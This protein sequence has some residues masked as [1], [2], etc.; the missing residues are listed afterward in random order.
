MAI[1][2]KLKWLQLLLALSLLLSAITPALAAPAPASHLPEGKAGPSMAEATV[3]ASAPIPIDPGPWH[4]DDPSSTADN[5]GN[6]YATWTD[7]RDTKT[8]IRF[9]SMH[10]GDSSWQPSTR[11][12]ASGTA[13]QGSSHIASDSNGNLYAVWLDY[14]SGEGQV[15]FSYRPAGGTWATSMP[16]S[17]T[18][19]SQG[20]PSLAV[21]RRGDAVVAW[22]QRESGSYH[23][24]VF[25]ALRSAGGTWGAA[26]QLTTTGGDY[27]NTSVAIDNWGRAYAAW[28]QRNPSH[29]AFAMRPAGG[30][31]GPVEFVC[32]CSGYNPSIAV[33][34]AGN[35][36]AV[37]SSS[38][39]VAAYRPAGGPWSA[40]VQLDADGTFPGVG[41]DDAGNAIAVWYTYNY[42]DSTALYR[43]IK[44]A[45]SN[46]SERELL[47]SAP[48]TN[49]AASL[50]PQSIASEPLNSVSVGPSS[51]VFFG[52]GDF[53]PGGV[54]VL[55]APA[56][57]EDGHCDKMTTA[58]AGA[59][60]NTGLAQTG[61]GNCRNG[62]P[63]PPQNVDGGFIGPPGPPPGTQIGGWPIRTVEIEPGHTVYIVDTPGVDG[64]YDN[65]A[66][67][68]AF[69]GSYVYMPPINGLGSLPNPADF[70]PAEAP[71]Q[72]AAPL[73]PA[74]TPPQVPAP[75]TPPQV[76]APP[77]PPQVIPSTQAEEVQTLADRINAL[78]KDSY[79][80]EGAETLV[81][82]VNALVEA[83]V[84]DPFAQHS[85]Y[86]LPSITPDM[87]LEMT[88]E[89]RAALEQGVAL[90]ESALSL[91]ERIGAIS[92]RAFYSLIPAIAPDTILEMT[93]EQ[94]AKLE[95]FVTQAESSQSL[96]FPGLEHFLRPFAA[97]AE[98]KQKRL[99]D[100]I[101]PASGDFVHSETPLHI[102]GRGLDYE[103][104]VSYHAQLVYD[105]PVGWGWTHNDDRRVV[106]AGAGSLALR[107]GGGRFDV[108]S[109][110]GTNFT[111]PA[112]VYTTIVSDTAGIIITDRYGQV[113]TYYPLDDATAPGALRSI[114][115]RNGN[116]LTF[117]YDAQGRLQTVT[118]TLGRDITY[119][120]DANNR[121]TSVTDF[122]GRSVTLTY[123]S[124]GDL[125]SITT[126]AVTGTPNGNDF[127]TGKTTRFA[128][129]SG[130]TD[131]RLNHN[132]T[133][134]IAPN[135]VAD[136]SL[137][138]R[139][140]N[141]Y[142]TEG[143]A[144]DRV[145]S[146]SWGGGR[147]NASGIP[148][149][150]TVTLVY[151]STVAANDPT[152]TASKT[153]ITDR[154]GNVITLWYDGAGHRLRSRQTVGGQTLTTDYAYNA[155][156]LLTGTTYPAGNQVAYT[157]DESA[158]NR[159]ARGNMLTM[160][161]IADVT[162]GCDGLGSTPC[163]DRVT[164]FTYEATFQ[165]IKTITDSLGHTAT[166]DYDTHGNLTKVTFPPVTVGPAAPQTAFESWTYNAH[167]QPLTFTDAEGNVTAYAYYSSGLANGYRQSVTLDSGGENLTTTY[168]VDAVGRTTAVTDP[169]GVRTDFIYNALDQVVKTTR[170]ATRNTQYAIRYWY[171]ANDNLVRT[172]TENV[173]P[174][175]D[176]NAHPTGTCSRDT[177]N[178]WF[179]TTF[180]YDLLDNVIT[181]S[182]EISTTAQAVTT[183]RYDALE[184][185]VRS[186]GPNGNRTE[187]AYDE[188]NRLTAETQAAGTSDAITTTFAYDGNGNLVQQLDGEGHPTGYYYDGFDNPVGQVDALGNIVRQAYDANGNRTGV[189]ML[190]GQDGRNPGRTFGATTPVLLSQ[191]E[192]RFDERNRRYMSRGRFFTADVGSGTITPITTDGNGDG[193]VETAFRWD[194]NGNLAAL[195]DD[196]GNTTTFAYDGLNRL[197]QHTDALGNTTAYTYDGNSNLT[198]TVS[199]DHQPDA[200]TADQVFIT[201]RIYD[202]LNRLAETSDSLGETSRLAYDSRS[203]TVFRSDANGPVAGGSNDHGNTTLYAYDGL[204]RRTTTT[205]HL[206]A[207]GTGGGAVT[208][209]A[210]SRYAYDAGGNLVRYT[211]PDGNV[212]RYSYDGLDRLTGTTFADGT[213][214]SN[215]YNRANNLVQHTDANGS[216]LT[217]SYDALNRRV[218]TDVARAAGVVGSTRQTFAYDGL[219]RLTQATDN[220]DPADSGDDSA[221]VFSY[222]SLNHVRSETQDGKTVASTYDGV[223]NR[224]TQT[225]PGG[226]TLTTTYDA[227][228]RVKTISDGS[229]QLASYDYIGPWRVFRRSNAN[230][231]YVAYSYDGVS[232]LTGVDHRLS[233]DDSL[234]TGFTCALDRAGHVLTETAQPGGVLTTY[235]YDS[236]YRLTGYQRPGLT[237]AFSYDAAGNRTEETRNGQVIAYTVDVMNRYTT[238]GGLPQSYDANGNLA[239]DTANIYRYDAFN[240]LAGSSVL[241]WKLYLPVI[242]RSG[243]GLSQTQTTAF[244][245]AGSQAT[246]S[247]QTYDALNRR[248]RLTT[249]STTVRFLHDHGRAIE[250]RDGSDALVASY[251]GDL[252]M[253]R[254]GVRSFYQRDAGGSTRALA[255]TGGAVVERVDY[256]AFGRPVFSGGGDA[257]ALGNPI[258]WHGL[259]YD[260]GDGLYVLG[261]RRYDPARG[262]GLQP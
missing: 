101:L 180:A 128:Y 174:D 158:T 160:R 85:F 46:W 214:E 144:F 255:N 191:T 126:P 47:A 84:Q 2:T 72:A 127:P 87:I 188:Q 39:A 40:V 140:V 154:G 28:N 218:Q 171:D 231:T 190:D 228:N 176:A 117:A 153:I 102:A 32:D 252:F 10:H 76:P 230:G 239:A 120:Y 166:R 80:A 189:Q 257:S 15:H 200:L 206:R 1:R 129:T 169:R 165:Q 234:L 56:P 247:Q 138:A 136:G 93:P 25:A 203:N 212:T 215:V 41:V 243:G 184:R 196:R 97:Q 145:I 119:S 156:G 52:G 217:Y 258:L 226:M 16:I 233:S 159:L 24:Q 198:Q 244:G 55:E 201:T 135:E 54:S 107:T 170:A 108:Y 23:R 193:W 105:G 253:V 69:A 211:D 254:G 195:T 51:Y 182:V 142:G 118:D 232:R 42:P 116:T 131:Q 209:Q 162:R 35:V 22:T 50:Q 147:S 13:G 5:A 67:A 34:G 124:N 89:Q 168:T 112:G 106:D 17:A 151:T 83:L 92:Q 57:G 68:Q 77:K 141:T 70:P 229:G 45:G 178:P 75:T 143:F 94:R 110:D 21:N 7:F 139:T 183:Y 235:S 81:E 157:Y 152:G 64:I 88:P 26:A 14:R 113:E 132:L 31:W 125:T 98:A 122:T 149:G 58:Q 256:E 20:G 259:R 173:A 82:R 74:N 49:V 48:A 19:V 204:S 221:T 222:G 150:G 66:D 111:P 237:Q 59:L 181:R 245:P 213:T 194:R 186:I 242:T 172:D 260:A 11:L 238:I 155:D 36:H 121:I 177:A 175:L 241:A 197:N 130:F 65:P 202:A 262:R 96:E 44:Y 219:S 185:P 63:A 9:S 86:A 134:I 240:R 137:T 208:G 224:I 167:G 95:Q 104:S 29:L 91:S 53:W 18:V 62:A 4:Q 60:A 250:E 109:F 103:F 216:V 261:D 207:G 192:Y 90:A 179:T 115:D 205:R 220:N 161:R 199:T 187:Y 73:P 223:G 99:A 246:G 3:P 146:Q 38:G 79:Q 61:G 236:L 78:I 249:G 133:T 37:W 27:D 251:V 33:D 30:P 100:P 114:A 123:D 225:Y 148:A 163:A 71:P 43:S 248:V 6:I 210:V 227:L 164:A 8:Q 12:D